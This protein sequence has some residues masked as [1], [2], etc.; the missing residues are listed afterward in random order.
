MGSPPGVYF[1]IRFPELENL[2]TFFL[3]DSDPV[4]PL[5]AGNMQSTGCRLDSNT[6]DLLFFQMVVVSELPPAPSR[7]VSLGRPSPQLMRGKPLC[8][9]GAWHQLQTRRFARGGV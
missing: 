1:T 8:T 2:Q 4:Y 5:Y 7:R 9:C 3:P 6:A